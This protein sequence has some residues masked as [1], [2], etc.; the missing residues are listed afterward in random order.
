LAS[1]HE[2]PEVGIA[3]VTVV[4]TSTAAVEVGACD[5][6]GSQ[7]QNPHEGESD[8]I[9]LGVILALLGFL[10]AVPVLWIIGLVLIAVGVILW[11]AG[12]VGNGVG[13]RRHYY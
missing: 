10:L 9:I 3:A 8:M 5:I 13:G 12:A 1:V 7:I 2:G 4:S 11:I 6:E